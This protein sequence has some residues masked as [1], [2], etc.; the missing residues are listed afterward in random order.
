MSQITVDALE[1][2]H[3]LGRV[4]TNSF[5]QIDA[6]EL[7]RALP[8]DSVDLMITDPAYESLE[9]HRAK[10]T[11]TRLKQ[12]KASSN[13]WFPIFRNHLYQAFFTELY[14]VMK[15]CTHAYVFCDETTDD[16]IK[17]IAR[18]VGFW[19]WKSVIWVKT[20][21]TAGVLYQQLRKHLLEHADK[22][23]DI[24]QALKLIRQFYEE[25]VP[26]EEIADTL[27]RTG[28]GYHWRG[29]CER[30]LFLEKRST[31][32]SWPQLDPTGRGKQLHFKGWKDVLYG[33]PVLDSDAYPTTKPLGVVEKL[34]L[35]S[36]VPGDLVIDPFAGSG[37][38]GNAARLHER[39]FLL[40]DISP[41]AIARM[42]VNLG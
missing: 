10:G 15:P 29:S 11:T 19:V 1:S 39:C 14:R 36:S 23:H 4:P 38:V 18:E 42:T 26:T 24:S 25:E 27:T 41:K 17:P 21:K 22:S 33:A 7:L 5:V 20:I 2:A 16:V 32:Q 3:L 35:N 40:G 13:E 28:M 6:I 12:S 8:D 34:V 30:I 9:K 31:Q 37:V